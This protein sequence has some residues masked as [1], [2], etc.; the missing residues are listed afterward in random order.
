MTP[1]RVPRAARRRALLA[2][3][4]AAAL[5]FAAACG[6]SS[7]GTP[8]GSSTAD[9][10]STPVT[11][12][13]WSW[14]PAAAPTVKL[15]E[16]Q[17]PNIKI[18]LVNA[19]Q[20]AAEYTKL[21]DAEKGGTGAPDVAQIEYF[22]LPQ[23]VLSK[24]VVNL[25]SYGAAS[26]QSK[27]STSAWSQVSIDGGVYGYPQDTGPMVMFYRKDI[28]T[29]LG[30]TVP[31]T[32]DEFQ[33]DAVKI[34]QANPSDYIT[35]IDP[36]DAGGMD[37]LIWA[38]GGTPFK[39]SNSTDV[40]T[41]LS[42]TG[43]QKVATL[44]TDMLQQHLVDPTA[45]WTT[46]WWNGM[47]S[48]EFATWITG[49]WA[50]GSIAST[51]PQTDSDWAVA[52]MPQ[53]TAG[54]DVTSQN[55]GSSDAVMATSHHKAA[56]AAFAQWLNTNSTATASLTQN[57][58]FPATTA[59]LSSQSFLTSPIAALDGQEGNKVFVDASEH[60][61]AGWQYLPYQ[62]YANSVYGDTVGQAETAG[63]SVMTGLQSWQT[64]IDSYGSRQGF[65]VTKG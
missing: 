33:A 20:S 24:Q 9:A 44:W 41:N 10:L 30:L 19:G 7:G 22:A 47:S 34:H 63:T 38:A 61:A 6:S 3:P 16:K 36:S 4:A 12:T 26:L 13:F 40:T 25:D 1:I 27:Y 11:L 8:S 35:S 15:F 43:A 17:Y 29:R 42:D 52:P 58:L 55:G 18:N 51:I 64:Q 28:F 62:V 23:F 5:A 46:D 48:G 31:T 49:A 57:G 32:W 56:A 14:T 59:L 65:T 53:W 21:A 60:V 45:G 39:T 50:P 2:L 37:S 54:A